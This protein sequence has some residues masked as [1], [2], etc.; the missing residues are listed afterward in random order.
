MV[1]RAMDGFFNEQ[2]IRS[3]L[4]TRWLAKMAADDAAEREA[5]EK[6]KKH[7]VVHKD[8]LG[9][10]KAVTI[11]NPNDPHD[12]L[13]IQ[14]PAISIGGT[15]LNSLSEEELERIKRRMQIAKTPVI[16]PIY[17]KLMEETSL[18]IPRAVP[19][20]GALGLLGWDMLIRD[21]KKLQN[22]GLIDRYWPIIVAAGL[23]G[24]GLFG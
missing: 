12:K 16:G 8:W 22:A 18:G 23:G 10:T 24:L 15:R 21:K 6:L 13:T 17:E 19:V 11:I 2:T 20:L 14:L 4:L 9:R 7:F 3:Q 5:L 1:V